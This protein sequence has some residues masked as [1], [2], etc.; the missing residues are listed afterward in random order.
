MDEGY[1]K[2]PSKMRKSVCVGMS[3]LM[4]STSLSPALAIDPNTLPSNGQVVGGSAAL[5][6]SGD[7]L[8]V[9]QSS[10]RAVIHWDS[11]DIGAAATT[12]FHQPSSSATA[13]NRVTASQDPS[14]ILGSLKAN[15]R[16]IVLNP[17]GMIFGK[18]A[19]VDVGS[20]VASTGSINEADFMAG[21]NILEIERIT[22]NAAS[23]INEGTIS[24]SEA[25]LVALVAPAVKNRGLITANKGKVTLASGSRATLDFY[26]DNLI[27]VAADDGFQA[28]L[29][30]NTGVIQ[31]QGGTVH[32]TVPRAQA[33]LNNV[34]NMDGVIEAS[35]AT[36][37]GGSIIL[38]GGN[39]RVSGTLKADG[40]TGGGTVKVGGD[41]LG[42]GDTTNARNTTIAATAEITAN[43]TQQGDGGEVIV[44]ADKDTQFDGRIE[45]KGKGAGGKG[46]FVE[47][48]G[49]ERLGVEGAVE[50]S[51]E[52]AD[53][54]MWLLDPSDV[55]IVRPGVENVGT[56]TNNATSDSFTINADSIETA[57]ATGD[58]TITTNNGAGTE[59]G[60]IF[61]NTTIDWNSSRTLYLTADNQITV[62]QAI[63][64]NNA[65]NGGL[66][67]T[68]NS[69]ITIGAAITG[70]NLSF[71]TGGDVIVNA[72]IIG[73][74]AG[75]LSFENR[76][77]ATSIGIGDGT[78]GT[79]HLSNTELS[80]I[81]G[82][83]N[84]YNGVRFGGGNTDTLNVSNTGNSWAGGVDL[85]AQAAGGVINVTGV[86]DLSAGNSVRTYMDAETININSDITLGP[87]YFSADT[88]NINANLISGP[89]NVDLR[90]LSTTAGRSMGIGDGATGD[91]T[92]STAELNRIQ[93]GFNYIRFGDDNITNIDLRGHS[94]NDRAVFTSAN[95]IT[96]N[97]AQTFSGAGYD[98]FNTANLTIDAALTGLGNYTMLRADAIAV[99]AGVAGG[100]RLRLSTK[101][102]GTIMGIGTGQTGGFQLSNTELDRFTG[103]SQWDIDGRDMGAINMGA[104]DW[105]RFDMHQKYV[106]ADTVNINGLQEFDVAHYYLWADTFAMGGNFLDSTT[107]G[108]LR[109]GAYNG[110][111][112]I[113][114]GLGNG[115]SGDMVFDDTLLGRIQA[116][117]FSHLY[118]GDNAGAGIRDVDIQNA[119]WNT[120]LTVFTGGTGSIATGG[121][122][123]VTGGVALALNAPSITI[124]GNVNRGSS[125]LRLISDTLNVTGNINGTAGTGTLSIGGFLNFGLG[126]GANANGGYALS[127]ADFNALQSDFSDVELIAG[128]GGNGTLDLGTIDWTGTNYYLNTDILT[129][130]VAQ[131]FGTADMEFDIDS[132]F[133]IS[134]SFTGT[135][136]LGFYRYYNTISLGDNASGGLHFSDAELNLIDDTFELV[137]FYRDGT[138][139]IGRNSAWNFNVEFSTPGNS[140]STINILD[141][142][143]FGGYDAHFY[144]D[145]INLDHAITGTGNIAF[146]S[147]SNNRH[148]G[149]GNG[150]TGNLIFA[151]ADLDRIGSGFNNVTFGRQNNLANL[152][153]EARN[154]THNV[155]FQNNNS[156]VVTINGNQDL[157]SYD[158]AF[159]TRNMVLNGDLAGTGTLLFSSAYD[160]QTVGL[161]DN[162]AGANFVVS[163]ADLARVQN[164][165]SLLQIGDENAGHIFVN[166][167]G[168]WGYDG[169]VRFEG[170]VGRQ[171]NVDEAIDAG[172]GGI[173]LIGDEIEITQNIAGNGA[174]VMTAANEA[175]AIEIGSTNGG[176]LNLTAAELGRL[177]DGFSGITIGGNAHAATIT[178]NDVVSFSDHT[179]I[180]T[181][182]TFPTTA[183]IDI[184]ASITTTDNSD[185]TLIGYANPGGVNGNRGVQVDAALNVARDL[186]ITALPDF[187]NNANMT[188]GRDIT[189]NTSN[190]VWIDGNIDAGRN[191]S[192]TKGGGQDTYILSG[193]S[194][195]A[196][197]DI[198]F[199]VGGALVMQNGSVLDSDGNISVK[200]KTNIDLNG[201]SITTAGGNITL[202]ADR[203]ANASGNID[204][205]GTTITT[206][207]G[208]FIAGGGANPLTTK[209]KA[210]QDG[211]YDRGV[212][213]NTT[214][215]T[216]SGGAVSIRGEGED[217]GNENFGVI[218][219]GN[220]SINTGSGSIILEGLGGNGADTNDGV[221][222]TSAVNMQTAGNDTDNAFITITGTAKGTGNGGRG[223]QNSAALIQS[224]FGDITLT[225]IGGVDSAFNSEGVRL[226]GS[227]IRSVGAGTGAA[228]INIIGTGG[229]QNAAISANYGIVYSSSAT[230]NTADGD[231]LFRGVGG[232]TGAEVGNSYGILVDGG[233]VRTIESTAGAHIT[234]DAQGGANTSSDFHITQAITVGEGALAGTASGDI[235]ILADGFFATNSPTFETIGNIVIAPK[236]ASTTIG[237]G[238]GSGA[239][240]LDDTELSYFSAAGTLTIGD[241][242]AGTGDIDVDSWDLSG[243][244][245]SVELYGNDI[246]L[247]G[248][249]MGAGSFMA[250]AKDK[251]ADAG[252][253]FISDNITRNAD[254]EATLELRADRDIMSSNSADIIATDANSDADGD[255]TT[256]ADSLNVIFNADRDGNMDGAVNLPAMSITTLGGDLTIGG[257][258]N[259]L[260]TSVYGNSSIA[261]GVILSGAPINTG[262]GNISIRG[263]GHSSANVNQHGV[264]IWNGATLNT[265]SGTID[266]YGTGGAGTDENHGVYLL[267]AT[268][269]IIAETGDIHIEGA[270]Q[271]TS[272]GNP[273]H[274]V[275][276]HDGATITS[277][278]N[279]AN[280]ATISLKGTG[281]N[282]GVGVFVKGGTITSG[283]GDIDITGN[284]SPRQGVMISN[285]DTTAAQSKIISTG[286]DATAKAADITINGTGGSN[287]VFL[288]VQG[289]I[290]TQDGDVDITGSGS[291]SGIYI[292][293]TG[294]IDSFGNGNVTLDGTATGTTSAEELS[295]VDL[296]SSSRISTVDGTIDITGRG[297]NSVDAVGNGHGISITEG[298]FDIV[299]TGAGDIILNGTAGDCVNGG[300]YGVYLNEAS[301]NDHYIRTTSTGEINITGRGGNTGS[302]NH[303]IFVEGGSFI[304]S[305]MS[306]AITLNGTGGAGIDDN[307]GILIS[308]SDTRIESE[309]G[310][311]S[312]TG[313]GGDA[314]GDDN[315]GIYLTAGADI[316]SSGLTPSAAN[317]SLD[318]TGGNGVSRNR[319]VFISGASPKVDTTFGDITVVARGGQ[320]V[321]GQHNQGYSSS[322]GGELRSFGSTEDAGNIHVTGT[323][324]SG[325]NSNFGITL[326]ASGERFRADEGDITLIGT[327]NGSGTDNH[328]ISIS[329]ANNAGVR[330][331]GGDIFMTGNA[332]GSG[333]GVG[334][335]LGSGRIG[336]AQT[337]NITLT[338]DSMVSTTQ[339]IIANGTLTITPHTSTTS[340]GLGAG[341]GD[342]QLSAADIAL[343]SA[344]TL[345]IGAD[346]YT[347]S[348]DVKALNLNAEVYDLRLNAGSYTLTDFTTPADIALKDGASSFDITN[349][350]TADSLNIRAATFNIDGL[351]A[352]GDV[353]LEATA[354][355]IDLSNLNSAAA[356]DLKASAFSVNGI[357]AAGSV[358]LHSS[359]GDIMLA[360]GVVGSAASGNSII[361]AAEND[362]INDAGENAL[363]P[364]AGRFLVYARDHRTSELGD[365]DAA[366]RYNA[367]FA[368]TPPSEITGIGSRFIFASQ[369]PVTPTIGLDLDNYVISN[370]EGPVGVAAMDIKTKE[371]QIE[372]LSDGK[373]GNNRSTQQEAET[374][375]ESE[376]AETNESAEDTSIANN[377]AIDCLVTDMQTGVCVLQ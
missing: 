189:I 300:C 156:S 146:G 129:T 107:N 278:G 352:T 208:D 77:G 224:S 241:S 173:T 196:A 325:T 55:F 54:G 184:N 81:T 9:H 253:I 281:G 157:G 356:V 375:E 261:Q 75:Y 324:G 182:A 170:G 138:V 74:N 210:S 373:S 302:D 347:G 218:L 318:G 361:L 96:V 152:N 329:A 124:N 233:G 270:G 123:A 24:A 260:T 51:S 346:D 283:Y 5:N 194:I 149:L 134:D 115:A 323:G 143:D 7:R 114:I 191:F 197:G 72:N 276:L 104:Y 295:G 151:D 34:I 351:D 252:Q 19:Q 102:N 192:L 332:N 98:E 155:T 25:G 242:V 254:G 41:Y 363:D 367:T 341:A 336:H 244:S 92:F 86:T 3:A 321:T 100:G 131:D 183:P 109:Y 292:R 30:E 39:I 99:N 1:T 232:G 215:I 159:R 128:A 328:G 207:G 240:N 76:A 201:V 214:T 310:D 308:G 359:V 82:N 249:T 257:G 203:D 305:T 23:I 33:L 314:T 153:V 174:L 127:R 171:V 339:S 263:T 64:H 357:N 202:N 371:R 43:A 301:H 35:S 144:S 116:G 6:Y 229:G 296:R 71:R 162:T 169:N 65:S 236:F 330:A 344:S 160:N 187:R 40:K 304:E 327:G 87:T 268:T 271:L 141:A 37:Q 31:A 165:F 320:N 355:T 78:A 287:G 365:I 366:I 90:F 18:D 333:T 154:W 245:H 234:F 265:T 42:Q 27:H 14:Q 376:S 284:A 8:D 137:R 269:A 316:V 326:G 84:I 45:A 311:I 15:G 130:S 358:Q 56:G 89:G 112:P 91:I 47:T 2:K 279:D 272:T 111:T 235:I 150:S 220:T 176:S 185:L 181:R 108:A 53:G 353:T 139:N 309:N 122:I 73:N 209:T 343:F 290:E 20:L 307:H 161:G 59:S 163:D 136:T 337:N 299:S 243:K 222:I 97:G 95:S 370:T 198:S 57:L 273:N 350:T 239:L 223:I 61:V 294:I 119:S 26:G 212:S 226:S 46:G 93:D 225:G 12:E 11:F 178:V 103:W 10:N 274:G 58:V 259:P 118:F 79:L 126:D 22:D 312:I 175:L 36:Q 125:D 231:I 60:N 16:V 172:T 282:N 28:A 68:A 180:E 204:I 88:Y 335:N 267:D 289:A 334:L 345:T 213:I 277:S 221:R 228:E 106:R 121:D 66:V 230:M 256:D 49:K 338:A 285:H 69:D 280:A 167:A 368:D 168:A 113:D 17:N 247:G 369:A 340:I 193:H 63:T 349:L 177:Q 32:M 142:E 164:G 219:T 313:A 195:D 262:A 291:V 70:R 255:A 44:W 258:A 206:N 237:L 303:G 250:T 117:G 331:T 275:F 105:T 133:A 315:Y 13:L 360:G 319:G 246:D 166:T 135:G 264:Y 140:A 48:S 266:I 199:D 372:A 377:S 216:T 362:F 158:A 205:S 342:L 227:T 238:G 288:H 85:R 29:L 83:F 248:I 52:Q 132:D 217:T 179:R 348:V 148:I 147:V 286:D 317:I 94:W 101:T 110:N 120:A 62:N 364:G 374:S 38:G 298:Q 186:L 190:T 80:R 21:Q 4:V 50:V 322:N 297:G 211:V 67:L 354:G 293:F 145:N 200:S 188:A 251:V 306:G